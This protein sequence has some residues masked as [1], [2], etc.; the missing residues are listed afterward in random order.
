M[1]GCRDST[2]IFSSTLDHGTMRTD[3]FE[4]ALPYWATLIE[5]V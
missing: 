5:P 3:D 4:K 1:I 2:T